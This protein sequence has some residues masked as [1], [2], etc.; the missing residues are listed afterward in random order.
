MA[1]QEIRDGIKLEYY[2]FGEGDKYILSC[3]FRQSPGTSYLSELAK[4]GY[5]VFVLTERGYGKSTHVFEDYGDEWYNIWADDTVSFADVL[6]IKTFAYTGHSNGAGVGWHILLRHP[7]RVN[8]F[9]PIAGGPH[10][11]NGEA[12][13]AI[14]AFSRGATIAAAKAGGE[15]W[16]EYKKRF[17]G[18]YEVKPTGDETPEER[19]NL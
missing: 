8:A 11:K 18:Y 14:S 16:I 4:E 9:M 10:E 1:I 3:D 17:V 6:G 5:H 19:V 12:T 13:D 2:E 7:Q 15:E